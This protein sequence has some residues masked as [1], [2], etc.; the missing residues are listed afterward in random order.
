[1]RIGQARYDGAI[2]CLSLSPFGIKETLKKLPVPRKRESSVLISL[3][4]AFCQSDFSE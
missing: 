2:A 1:M 4:F 3:D